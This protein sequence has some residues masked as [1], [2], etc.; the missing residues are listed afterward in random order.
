MSAW[1]GQLE[2]LRL[3]LL[4]LKPPMS[5]VQSA[6]QRRDKAKADLA[7]AVAAQAEA[8]RRLEAARAEAGRAAELLEAAEAELREAGGA[9][10][11][12]AA[13]PPIA[14]VA[15]ELEQ[16]AATLTP[17]ELGGAVATLRRLLGA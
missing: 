3:K 1:N 16:R 9:V 5:R 10:A 2:G 12:E 13:P 7:T 17:A 11:A 15:R 4:S 6:C 14:V 8:A